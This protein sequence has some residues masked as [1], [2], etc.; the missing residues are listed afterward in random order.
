MLRRESRQPSRL[1]SWRWNNRSQ[2]KHPC[3]YNAQEGDLICLT[4]FIKGAVSVPGSSGKVEGAQ[5]TEER[6]ISPPV[7]VRSF[8]S[9]KI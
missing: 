5:D 3:S 2:E 8:H 7:T 9:D 1:G 6:L 4:W